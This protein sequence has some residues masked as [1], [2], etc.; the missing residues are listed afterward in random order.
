M[1]Y[2]PSLG[3]GFNIHPWLLELWSADIACWS[4]DVNSWFNPPHFNQYYSWGWCCVL[5][6]SPSPPFAG[7]MKSWL[8]L[9]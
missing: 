3:R 5:S 2:P 4:A 6:L 8:S 7:G 9:K 1:P